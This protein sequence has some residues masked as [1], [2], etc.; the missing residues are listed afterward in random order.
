MEN[1]TSASPLANSGAAGKSE[2]AAAQS[3]VKPPMM[4]PIVRA[5]QQ[6]SV[7]DQYIDM[8]FQQPLQQHALAARSL[9]DIP[10]GSRNTYVDNT[11]HQLADHTLSAPGAAV[12][13]SPTRGSVYED[14]IPDRNSGYGRISSVP[15]AARSTSD[16]LEAGLNVEPFSNRPTELA[17]GSARMSWLSNASTVTPTNDN[18]QSSVAMATTPSAAVSSPRNSAGGGSSGASPLTPPSGESLTPTHVAGISLSQRSRV[19][20]KVSTDV[21]NIQPQAQMSAFNNNSG[22]N[23]NPRLSDPSSQHTMAAANA[24]PTSLVFHESAC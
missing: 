24:M 15:R 11:Y 4:R 23:N 21:T 20:R 22:V 14:V 16:V 18:R 19:F 1:S 8:R 17:V 3:Q 5:Q 10:S 13:L 2:A 6:T 12:H 7:H 9:G